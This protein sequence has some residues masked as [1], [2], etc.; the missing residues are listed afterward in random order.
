[1]IFVASPIKTNSPMPP[2]FNHQFICILFALLF[3]FQNLKCQNTSYQDS[4]LR[5]LEKESGYERI[6]TLIDLYNAFKRS[7]LQRS[8]AWIK[9]AISLGEKHKKFDNLGLSYYCMGALKKSLEQM[10]SSIF[11]LKK[12]IKV[13]KQEND[14][15]KLAGAY[16]SI[17]GTFRLKGLYDQA[18]TYIDSSL[19]IST[20]IKDSLSTAITLSFL[21]SIHRNQ[22][23]YKIAY[24]KELEALKLFEQMG[25]QEIREADSQKSIGEI[26]YQREHYDKAIEHYKK[27]LSVYQRLGDDQFYGLTL[28]RISNSHLANKNIESAQ[29]YLDTVMAFSQAKNFHS[30][31]STSQVILAGIHSE[32][33]NYNTAISILNKTLAEARASKS[34]NNIYSQLLMLGGAYTELGKYEKALNC[35]NE[36]LIISDTI[37]APRE[38]QEFLEARS[39]L[40]AK[41]SNFK[42]A[43]Y[44]QLRFVE[45]SDSL[46]SVNSSKAIEELKTIY[47][48]EKQ[49]QHILLQEKDIA[50]LRQKE[51]LAKSRSQQLLLGLIAIALISGLIIYALFN[52]KKRNEIERE[53]LESSLRYKSKQLTTHAMNLAHKN[54]ILQQLKE[55][56]NEIKKESTQSYSYEKIISHIDRNTNNDQYWAEFTRYFEE[57]HKDFNSNALATYPKL[58]TNDLRLIALLKM[59]LSSKEIAHILNISNEGVKKARYRLRKKLNLE[60]VQSLEQV[61]LDI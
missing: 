28:N 17:A 51:S 9:E 33:G 37:N 57:V 21:S 24:Q 6:P 35:F 2:T 46:S 54:E 20:K 8:E 41:T 13:L 36:G 50:L 32:A 19:S 53:K 61:I 55:E 16:T 47:E 56:L 31:Y 23:R 29:L 5:A 45:I 60:T 49:K 48:T 30:I 15:T 42:K 43:Y 11:Y 22:G 34:I 59:N 44:D 1:M 52:K 4:L 39:K 14:T 25:N 7:D 38:T 26:E 12:G 18:I 40:Y 27:A 3:A 58:K 10:D